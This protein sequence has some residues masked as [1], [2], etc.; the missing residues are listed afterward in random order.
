MAGQQQKVYKDDVGTA[1]IIDMGQDISDAT[2]LS[3]NVWKNGTEEIWTP[4]VYES[5]YLR[6]VTVSGDLD[7]AGMYYLQPVL[8]F[9]DGWSGKGNTVNFRVYDEYR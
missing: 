4:E 1:I 2:S 9:P 5:N 8:A 3:L 7:V 6:Y